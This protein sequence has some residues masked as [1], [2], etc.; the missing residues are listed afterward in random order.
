MQQHSSF[1]GDSNRILYAS[2]L[3]PN[4][5]NIDSPCIQFTVTEHGASQS[6]R[7][8]SDCRCTKAYQRMRVLTKSV[9]ASILS[10]VGTPKPPLWAGHVRF[11]AQV[12]REVRLNRLRSIEHA[13]R[14]RSASMWNCG[15]RESKFVLQAW[16]VPIPQ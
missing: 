2:K 8:L 11:I 13:C 9:C 6:I 12:C 4:I 1:R 3:L 10:R 14:A 15:R 16:W 5:D 7:T